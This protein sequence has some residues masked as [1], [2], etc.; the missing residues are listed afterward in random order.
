M[1]HTHKFLTTF[2][3]MALLLSA[4]P[5]QNITVSATPLK[6]MAPADFVMTVN[7]AVIDLG[8]KLISINSVE[9]PQDL[10]YDVPRAH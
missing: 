1:N 6:P 2:T 3:I 8:P 7:I 9:T 5:A 4:I 10:D